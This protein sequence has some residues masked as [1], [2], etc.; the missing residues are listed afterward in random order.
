MRSVRVRQRPA[1]EPANP[2][3]RTR[4]GAASWSVASRVDAGCR[5]D[6]GSRIALAADLQRT[7]GN[8]AATQLVGLVRTDRRKEPPGGAREI[9]E[10]GSGGGRGLTLTSYADNSPIFLIGRVEE[11]GGTWSTRPREVR[12]PSLDHEVFYPAPGRHRLRDLGGSASQ[13]LDVTDDWSAR[14]LQGEEEHVDDNEQAWQMTWGR[15]A[16]VINEMANG[17]PFTGTTGEAAQAAAWREFR[18]RLPAALRPEGDTPT[19]QAQL[20]KWGTQD[21]GTIFRKLMR[22]TRR[23]RDDSQ[24]HTPDQNLKRMEGNDRIDELAVG[25][26]RIGQVPSQRLMSEAWDRLARG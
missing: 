4:A 13:Y 16:N 1:A 23:A 10:A 19:P 7:A 26:S 6:L 2:A 24:W 25:T 22:E 8:A 11:T 12:L 9:T 14:I 3:E 17:E 15:I 18:R 20:A 5:L 21:L